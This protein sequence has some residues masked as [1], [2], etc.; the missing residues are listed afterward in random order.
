MAPTFVTS[1]LGRVD[2]TVLHPLQ[3]ESNISLWV[4]RPSGLS[5]PNLQARQ[6]STWELRNGRRRIDEAK[7]QL[8]SL[9]IFG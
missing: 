4:I 6:R 5:D 9:S 8:V 7:N 2:L 3:V 1:S